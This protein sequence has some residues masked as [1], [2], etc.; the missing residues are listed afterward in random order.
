MKN[1]R[2]EKILELIAESHIETQDEL[3]EKLSECGFVCAQPTISRDIKQLHLIKEPLH[4]GHYH[5][6]QADEHIKIEFADRLQRILRMCALHCDYVNNLVVLK[7]MPGLADAAGAA[8]DTMGVS[9]MV[10]CVSGDDTVL[11]VM[12]E[13]QSA[14]EL[15]REINLLC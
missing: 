15:C 9:E 10:G 7:T 13:T 3:L 8:L 11:I 5:Y 14:R 2:H 6:V 1:K 12:R 4:G